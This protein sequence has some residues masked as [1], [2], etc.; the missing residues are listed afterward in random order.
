[1]PRGAKLTPHVEGLIA[2][3]CIEHPEWISKPKKIREWVTANLCESEKV[4]GGPNWPGIDVIKDRLRTKIRPNLENRPPEVKR[5]DEEWSLGASDENG[6]ST[7]AT[8]DLLDTWKHCLAIGHTFTV[9]EA[10]WVARM[11]TAVKATQNVYQYRGALLF[12]Y[13]HEYAIRE[14]ISEIS[15]SPM[16]TRDLDGNLCF[17]E[18]DWDWIVFRATGMIPRITIKYYDKELAEHNLFGI[19]FNVA[20]YVAEQKMHGVD[21][22]KINDLALGLSDKQAC[23]LAALL[24]YLSKGPLWKELSNEEYLSIL[25]YLKDLVM[26]ELADDLERESFNI[27][28][29]YQ[30]LDFSHWGDRPNGLAPEDV[31]SPDLLKLVGYEVATYAQTVDTLFPGRKNYP[32]RTRYKAVFTLNGKYKKEAQDERKHKTKKQK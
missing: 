12:G 7:E 28:F 13:A 14:R 25:D 6:I 3:A 26:K 4:W 5:L 31:L 24:L 2:T 22:N 17:Q 10:K 1:M 32:E 11:G 20:S 9:R 30:S 15:G 21:P 8:A 29:N 23:M 18:R 16:D 19:Y 27:K